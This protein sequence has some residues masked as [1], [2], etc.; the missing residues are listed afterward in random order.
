LQIKTKIPNVRI[1]RL[2]KL[3]I[4]LALLWLIYGHLR[5][6][7]AAM[8]WEAL[9]DTGR[10]QSKW[11]LLLLAVCLMPVNWML[12]ALKW[13]QFMWMFHSLDF[14]TAVRGV[15]AGISVSLFTPNRVGEYAGRMLVLEPKAAWSTV[16]ATIL[17]SYTQWMIL[18]MG[19]ATGMFVLATHRQL[20]T[21]ALRLLLWGFALAA[22]IAASSLLWSP[23]KALR[24]LFVLP[25][26]G[27]R[28][29]LLG[30]LLPLRRFNGGMARR[31]L[32]L[33]ALRYLVYGTQYF[34]LLQYMVMEIP[35]PEA[36]AGI[37]ALFLVQTGIPLPPF[38]AFLARGELALLL[39]GRYT[40]EPT[41]LLGAA[42]GLFTLNLL[43]PALWGGLVIWQSRWLQNQ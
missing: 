11:H 4:T 39:W 6:N 12:E 29:R 16:A 30:A 37:A 41:L 1:A 8:H 40:G 28:K 27:L 5:Q 3:G 2:L 18:W 43:L 13:Q 35:L 21:P 7:A 20:G 25:K 15:L 42:Y 32:G 10:L 19:G 31:V 26:G 17:G 14:R 24:L 23:R 38:A 34:L 36:I 22:G 33:A 9:T